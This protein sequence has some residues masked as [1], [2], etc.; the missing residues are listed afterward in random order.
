MG[1][2]P[3]ASSRRARYTAGTING[4]NVP[5]YVDEPG[6]DPAN[7]TETLAEATFEIRNERW[8]GVPFRLRSGKSLGDSFQGI[9]LHFR[10][11][12]HVPNGFHG[13]ASPN[14]LTVGIR[15][16]SLALRLTTN[17][18]GGRWDL[19]ETTLASELQLSP[20]RAY[21]EILEGVLTDDPLLSVRGDMAED[22]W[23][24]VTP[25]LDAW[26]ANKVPLDEYE[27]GS[28]GPTTWPS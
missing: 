8:A 20:L 11:V 10:P 13:T 1:G 25:I 4:R 16:D 27:A 15:P 2:Q 5:N 3:E 26:S 6:V 14:V 17:A 23:R 28:S 22:L 7:N 9:V 18:E 21:G 19:E 24:I 12:R